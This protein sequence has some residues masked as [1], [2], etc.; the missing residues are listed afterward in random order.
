M[1]SASETPSRIL[2]CS[3]A[4]STAVLCTLSNAEARSLTSLVD[5]WSTG[6]RGASVARSTLWP[7]RSLSTTSGSLI[8]ARSSVVRR[9]AP[10]SRVSLRPT[11][12]EMKIEN[13]TAIRPSAPATPARTTTAT[14][15]GSI[16]AS[17]LSPVRETASRYC[18]CTWS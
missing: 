15:S 18:C 8:S 10:S 6:M 12:T 7:L 16:L 9:S 14:P 13:T 2:A 11:R 1:R 17:S 3:T 4:A 5:F